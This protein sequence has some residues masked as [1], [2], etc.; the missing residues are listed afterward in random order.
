MKM[1]GY[2]NKGFAGRPFCNYLKRKG[3]DGRK[4]SG[5]GRIETLRQGFREVLEG[6]GRAGIE[7]SRP[8]IAWNC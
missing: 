1:D 7:L 6:F 2:Q 4:W 3:M 8:M 5:F